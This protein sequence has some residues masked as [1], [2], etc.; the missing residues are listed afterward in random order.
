M[1]DQSSNIF[2][3]AAKKGKNSP[4]KEKK[5]YKIDSKAVD[6]MIAQMKEMNKDLQEQIDTLC[7]K[8]GLSFEAIKQLTENHKSMD[9]NA[10]GKMAQAKKEFEQNVAT[11][12]KQDSKSA[13]KK[14]QGE[15]AKERKAKTLGAR[16]KW[17]PM[18]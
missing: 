10:W 11:I 14:T 1:A 7:K 4:K 13:P 2:E 17:I 3:E 5:S 15:I 9:P 16:K 6:K 12:V 8:T 18:K